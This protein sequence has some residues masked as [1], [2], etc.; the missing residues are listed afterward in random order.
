MS[1]SVSDLGDLRTYTGLFEVDGT[2][3]IL[4]PAIGWSRGRE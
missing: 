4:A 2:G 1:L 3:K